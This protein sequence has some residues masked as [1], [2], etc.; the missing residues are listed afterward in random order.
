MATQ[1]NFYGVY[2]P[3]ITCFDEDGNFAW[4]KQQNVIR[5]LI[6]KGVNG[7]WILGSY[8]A[9]PF[10]TKKERK[11]IAEMIINEVNGKVSIIDH[12]G[13]AST[14]ETIELAK[15]AQSAGAQAVAS[16]IPYYYSSFAYTEEQIVK[17]FGALVDSVDIPVF[18]YNNPRTTGYNVSP[19]LLKRLAEVGVKGVKDSSG[20]YVQMAE[21]IMR[22]QLDYPEFTFFT[23]TAALLLPS[24]MLGAQGGVAG[25]GNAFPEIVVDIYR[26]FREGKYKEASAQQ[27]LVLKVRDLQGIEGF[28]PASCYAML[29]MRGIDA[30]TVKA[31]WKEIPKDKYEYVYQELKRL[32]VL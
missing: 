9:F 28:R 4:E 6:E 14:K 20:N 7:L 24:L 22:V 26:L 11:E 32:G 15:H 16:V 30:G 3:M 8:G 2:P 29:R 13:S 19:E 27:N 25:T 18:L 10:F 17:H 21:Y 23:G 31:P 1:S 5:F 12:I